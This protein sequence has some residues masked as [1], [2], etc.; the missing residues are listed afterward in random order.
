MQTQPALDSRKQASGCKKERKLEDIVHH[1]A[2]AALC[3]DQSTG[4]CL[5]RMLA[6]QSLLS[7]V[8]GLSG[9]WQPSNG[10]LAVPAGITN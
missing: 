10:S 1:I 7:L 2:P 9:C 8:P 4:K 3:H 5:K 6:S